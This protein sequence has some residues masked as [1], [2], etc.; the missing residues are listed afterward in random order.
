MTHLRRASGQD[1]PH[2]TV[3]CVCNPTTVPEKRGKHRPITALPSSSCQ[4]TV[5]QRAM[6]VFH[7]GH[8]PG[9]V[10]P[11]ALVLH[12]RL[13]DSPTSFEHPRATRPAALESHPWQICKY[14]GPRTSACLSTV[15][16]LSMDINRIRAGSPET[17]CC[18]ERAMLSERAGVR[19]AAD[20]QRGACAGDTWSTLY[21]RSSAWS[22]QEKSEEQQYAEDKVR[23]VC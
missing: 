7:Q 1:A 18:S 9:H 12:A 11:R 17:S 8:C 21:D 19:E 22:L 6:I 16:D 10:C 13:E 23:A 4:R 5:Q 20:G 14:D 3:L 2:N 15:H